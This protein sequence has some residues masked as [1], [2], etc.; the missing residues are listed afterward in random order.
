MVWPMNLHRRKV[1]L[2]ALILSVSL[3]INCWE[4][5]RQVLLWVK[6]AV[7]ARLAKNPLMRAVRI[8]KMTLAALE[9]TL[10]HYQREQADYTYSGLAYDLRVIR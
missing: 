2:L 9:A 5:H 8:D 10:R 6:Q 1:S 3:A 7:I 4:D